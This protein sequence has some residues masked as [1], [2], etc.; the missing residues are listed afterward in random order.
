M[1]PP[2]VAILHQ[3]VSC[4]ALIASHWL[5]WVVRGDSS[6]AADELY[7]RWIRAVQGIRARPTE[8]TCKQSAP[9]RIIDCADC[10]QNL[11]SRVL[12]PRVDESTPRPGHAAVHLPLLANDRTLWKRGPLEPTS[13][14]DIRPGCSRQPRSWAWLQLQ[15]LVLNATTDQQLQHCWDGV[16]S[17]QEAEPL[18]NCDIVGGDVQKRYE[19]RAGAPA[20]K[21]VQVKTVK[22]A[23]HLLRAKTHLAKLIGLM[24]QH[25]VQRLPGAAKNLAALLDL[26]LELIIKPNSEQT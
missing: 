22:W 20:T 12:G 8:P 2:N 19:G 4:M 23:K 13:P 16:L 3:L 7:Q 6:M 24:I 10:T 1:D 14:P 18:D 21:L 9:G 17:G 26:G 5:D 25:L 11:L 15:E